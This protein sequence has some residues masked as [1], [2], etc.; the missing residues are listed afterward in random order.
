MRGILVFALV[1]SGCGGEDDGLRCPDLPMDGAT[2][3][4]G[5][6][7][8]LGLDF[9]GYDEGAD[10]PL[11]FGTQGGFHVW[12]H[13]SAEGLCE[14]S[15]IVETRVFDPDDEMVLFQQQPMPFDAAGSS[16]E[17]RAATPLILCPSSSGDPVED[18]AYRVSVEVTDRDGRVATAEKRFVAVC[19]ASVQGGTFVDDCHCL[20]GMTGC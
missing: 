3:T 16:V 13:L 12:M 11:V 2:V 17:L 4:I 7:D 5:G 6:A 14:G 20:C 8:E 18:T 1:L 15:V 10:R 19:D 9:A